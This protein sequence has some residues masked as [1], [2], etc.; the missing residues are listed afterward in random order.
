MLIFRN[1]END[2]LI[3][4]LFAEHLQPDSDVSSVV[5]SKCVPNTFYIMYTTNLDRE[6]LKT[7]YDKKPVL[8]GRKIE[9]FSS[10]QTNSLLVWPANN[11]DLKVFESYAGKIFWEI[12]SESK[13]ILVHFINTDD[14]NKFIQ[15]N[16]LSMEQVY[17]FE[18]V[19]SSLFVKTEP[20]KR[21]KSESNTDSNSVTNCK[22]VAQDTKKSTTK[23]ILIKPGPANA[24]PAAA[25]VK[26]NNL[27]YFKKIDMSSYNLDSARI[28]K[29]EMNSVFYL[30]ENEPMVIGLLNS[31]QLL[32]D[33]NLNLD[34][35]NHEGVIESIETGKHILIRLKKNVQ[36]ESRFEVRSS[37]IV[38]SLAE[39]YEKNFI[40][41]IFELSDELQ[42]RPD[43]D[44]KLK[45]QCVAINKRFTAVHLKYEKFLLF[46]YGSLNSLNKVLK[47]LESFMT[48]VNNSSLAAVNKNISLN[49]K[50]IFSSPNKLSQSN[51]KSALSSKEISNK[52]DFKFYPILKKSLINCH[53]ICAD[54]KE[55]LKAIEFELVTNENEFQFEFIGMTN[56]QK[57]GNLDNLN[58]VLFDYE[59]KKLSQEFIKIDENFNMSDNMDVLLKT[60]TD[61]VSFLFFPIYI[62]INNNKNKK[63]WK[64][65]KLR[66]KLIHYRILSYCIFRIYS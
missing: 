59:S 39:F 11:I 66:N 35:V 63:L 26:I 37:L 25:V 27:L 33:L 5:A 9:V 8:G 50:V 45:D 32:V 60:I 23:T 1:I 21:K 34:S 24:T 7:R 14:M 17:N 19:F 47:N 65:F 29:M 38:E 58:K 20:S 12:I 54:F 2:Q 61:E 3:V 31:S 30:N 10:F 44:D 64:N 51:N 42:N 16:G 43:L 6:K 18:E 53:K 48:T 52:I 22:S 49:T 4:K 36:S 62:Y 56:T 57:N 15:T 46:T 13:Y 55:D 28:I 41:Q 40:F